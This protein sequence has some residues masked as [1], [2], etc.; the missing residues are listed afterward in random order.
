MLIW[1]PVFDNGHLRHT[2]EKAKQM[3]DA[4]LS[5]MRNEES[6][7]PKDPLI[8]VHDSVWHRITSS[9]GLQQR[10]YK[11]MTSYSRGAL[12]HVDRESQ[13]KI[14]SIQ[15]QLATRRRSSGVTPLFALVE[16]AHGL[17]LPDEIFE[18]RS[19]KEI[20]RIGTDL[21]LLQNDILSY[22]KEE[23][24]GVNHNLVAIC[25]M[26][27]MPAQQAFDHVNTL[28][29]GC[30][31][32]WYFALADLPQW[33]EEIDNQVQKYIQGVQD[34]VLANLSWSFKSQ[35]YL[36]KTHDVVRQ[37]RQITVLP[38]AEDHII[39]RQRHW[40]SRWPRVLSAKVY[41][42]CCILVML[43]ASVGFSFSTMQLGFDRWA[44]AGSSFPILP[45]GAAFAQ[46]R[47]FSQQG[48]CCSIPDVAAARFFECLREVH[49]RFTGKVTDP[50]VD[51]QGRSRLLEAFNL[52]PF[53]RFPAVPFFATINLHVS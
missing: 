24:E 50:S 15:E 41:G 29:R 7:H 3:M 6:E 47:M 51:R 40:T 48:C 21:V 49:V 13:E 44:Y 43:F 33:G 37:T 2:P 52:L 38:R 22:P 53:V 16:Y 23:A 10:F 28:L 14:P 19:I 1:S 11:A 20:E 39:V 26:N 12:E 42:L 25:R 30:Y 8:E 31:R 17:D 46:T 5:V 32:D 9:V 35:R 27:G 4:L 18:H 45:A 34:V 36:G